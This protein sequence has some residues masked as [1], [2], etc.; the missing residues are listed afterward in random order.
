MPIGLSGSRPSGFTSSGLAAWITGRRLRVHG[1][2]L[3]LCLWS[4][5]AWNIASPGWRDRHGNL[6]GTD[7]S[8][9][10]TLGSVALAHR[11]V[12]LYDADAQAELASRLI[13][14]ATGIRYIPMYPPQVSIFFAPLAALPYGTTLVIWLAA[15]SLLLSLDR[16]GTDVCDS[17]RVL[18]GWLFPFAG[19]FARP[20]SVSGRT[21]VRMPDLQAATGNRRS[22]HFPVHAGVASDRGRH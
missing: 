2:I 10:Y 18:H 6:K 16:M 9:L 15:I 7:F 5:Y 21:G 1:T 14:A 12:D 17:A 20:A 19:R 4:V 13:P 11:A 8:H 22:L 3:A